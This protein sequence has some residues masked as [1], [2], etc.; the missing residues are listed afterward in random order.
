MVREKRDL[1]YLNPNELK[2]FKFLRLN[3]AEISNWPSLKDITKKFKIPEKKAK[4]LISSLRRTDGITLSSE[5]KKLGDEIITRY[6]LTPETIGVLVKSG[7][8]NSQKE[9][10]YCSLYL[11]K[12][13]FGTKAFDERYTMKGLALALEVNGLA[14]E[15][16][17]VI[18]QGGIIP[19]VPPF[20]SVSYLT[21]LKFLSQIDRT[22]DRKS[23]SEEML[24]EE[25]TTEFERDFY[26]KFV[27][28]DK[29]KK[30]TSLTEAF[31]AAEEQI[32]TLMNA[33]PE[34]TVLRMQLGHEERENIRFLEQ[35]QIQGFAKKKTKRIKAMKE[36]LIQDSEIAY[37]KSYGLAAKQFILEKIS[38]SEALKSKIGEKKRDYIKR[39]EKKFLD[40]KKIGGKLDLIWGGYPL[41]RTS[42]VSLETIWEKAKEEAFRYSYHWSKRDQKRIGMQAKELEDELEKIPKQKRDLESRVED[43]EETESWTKQLLGGDRAAITWFTR[44]Y[45]VDA[46]YA[47]FGWKKV[48][49]KFTKHFFNWHISNPTV[50]HVSPR[51]K[52]TLDTGIVTNV[53][54]KEKDTAEVEYRIHS[55]GKKKVMMIENINHISSNDIPA[56]AINA[57]KQLMNYETTVLKKL[58]EKEIKMVQPDIVLLG[59]HLSGGFRAMPWFKESEQL[60]EGEFV[61]A[62]D[63]SWLINLPTLQSIP[64]LEWLTA[65]QFRNWDVKRYLKGPYA[66]AAIAHIEDNEGV[67]KFSIMDNGF[68]VEAGKLAEQIETYRDELRDKSLDKETRS[69]IFGLIKEAKQK[70]KANFKKIEAA[71]DFH[72]GSPDQWERYSKDQLIKAAQSY[73]KRKGLPNIVC[74]DEILNGVEERIF[75]SSTRY[76]GGIPQKFERQVITPILESENLSNE[77]KARLIA[78]ESMANLRSIPIHNMSDQKDAFRW[79]C[80]PY[81]DRILENNGLLVLTS[82]N[83]ANQSQRLADEAQELANQFDKELIY[84]R[85]NKQGKIHV[86]SGKGNPV[87]VGTIRLGGN[88]QQKLF[89]IHKMPERMD[90]GYGGA[91]HLRKG[92]NDA[93]IIVYGDRH[94]PIAWYADGH[95]GTLHPGMEPINTYVPLI[96][97]PA[98][99]H[100]INNIFYDPD[101]RGIYQ[102]D[103]ILDDALEKII[104]AEN[105]I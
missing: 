33:L 28:N 40:A 23:I 29:K 36:D 8:S 72:L 53:K 35:A 45:P 2:L 22:S 97:K 77:E 49:D 98:G 102:V 10:N 104:E 70:V 5:T 16:Q 56:K 83:H 59:A 34:E 86:H 14:K 57:A 79:L 76:L 43:I 87:G 75:K 1:I 44:Q 89:T 54:T 50:I 46:D 38:S 37:A 17:E 95:L 99:I 20:S 52:V 78:K 74:Y 91:L 84:D 63:I 67:N 7:E 96:G 62:Q 81:L 21:A 73:Q 65:H 6:G 48:K 69:K 32:S 18:I 4:S 64:H 47:E 66:S 24:E 80:K 30:I 100:G 85:F 55:D 27:N 92:K 90:E 105:I 13:S 15:I 68:L 26:N 88:A 93:D 101:K 94:H 3:S 9:F 71:G 60:I 19:T 25:I 82:G 31:S 42:E 41:A 103:F 11:G 58:Y 61:G 39:I 51:K 12:P